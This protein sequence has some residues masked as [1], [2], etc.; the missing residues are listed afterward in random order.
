[1]SPSSTKQKLL[2]YYVRY[3]DG[4]QNADWITAEVEQT[5]APKPRRASASHT[6]RVKGQPIQTG[7]GSY[8]AA[9]SNRNYSEPPLT[10]DSITSKA[11][12]AT[13]GGGGKHAA[14]PG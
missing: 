4:Q 14:H 1:M 12:I 13:E 9:R 10:I 2:Q 11:T 5:V 6:A 3:I 7:S 8:R